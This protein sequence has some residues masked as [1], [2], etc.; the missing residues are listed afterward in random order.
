MKWTNKPKCS[1]VKNS[2]YTAVYQMV[3]DNIGTIGAVVVGGFIAGLLLGYSL[4]KVVKLI[5]APL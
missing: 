5:S 1:K 4:K 3:V 2:K